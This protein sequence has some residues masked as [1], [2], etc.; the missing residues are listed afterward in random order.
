MGKEVGTRVPATTRQATT[1]TI[2]MRTRTDSPTAKELGHAKRCS[3]S[4][5]MPNW[6]TPIVKMMRTIKGNT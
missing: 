6:R 5:R 3:T 4:K 1:Q 2:W